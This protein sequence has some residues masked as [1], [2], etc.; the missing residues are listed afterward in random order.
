MT[1]P[2]R[3][4]FRGGRGDN[5]GL[6]AAGGGPPS[7]GISVVGGYRN[8]LACG[9]ASLAAA[10]QNVGTALSLKKQSRHEQPTDY[11]TKTRR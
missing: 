1:P 9:A 2:L 3:D 4:L 8:I 7:V 5:G 11:G 6:L 10:H